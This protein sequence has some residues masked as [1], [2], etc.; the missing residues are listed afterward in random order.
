MAEMHEPQ[1][2]R[3]REKVAR[4][5]EATASLLETTSYDDLG[6]KLIA[7]E[8]GVSVGVLY[9][10]FADKEAIVASLVRSWLQLDV[11]I[12]ERVTSE[13]LPERSQDLLDK[14]ITAY[15]DRFR[16]EPGYRRIWYHGPRI[17]SLR[18]DTQQTD[19]EIADR[20]HRALVRG[21]AMPDTDES[22]RRGRL[23]V[24]VGS[25]L[26]GLAFR[27]DPMG[28]TEILADAALMMDRY[29]FAP[30]TSSD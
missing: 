14:L 1:Q 3:S 4:I 10:Y 7:A 5:L 29:L 23:A 26:L 19:R 17:A 20:I 9:R 11:Q 27:D 22:R 6:T 16:K 25:N 28:D 2:Q 30:P 24:E 8:A 13:P 18:A 21:Y 15:A 12:A